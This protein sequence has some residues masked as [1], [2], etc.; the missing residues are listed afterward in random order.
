MGDLGWRVCAQPARFPDPG[1]LKN[2]N[3]WRAAFDRC[4][5]AG[6]IA[7]KCEMEF[8]ISRAIC[9]YLAKSF[10]VRWSIFGR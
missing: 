2:L 3:V 8:E 4:C 6:E 10:K 5:G 7:S 9:I 1:T